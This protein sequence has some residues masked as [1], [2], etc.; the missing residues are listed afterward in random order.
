MG[1]W[2]L[3]NLR[4]WAVGDYNA[5]VD[6]K[7]RI[8]LRRNRSVFLPVKI[9]NYFQPILT[10]ENVN[11]FILDKAI[12]KHHRE[13]KWKSLN[14]IP[15]LITKAVGEERIEFLRD[16]QEKLLNE[17]NKC[18]EEHYVRKGRNFK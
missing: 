9:Q 6:S 15:N 18:T 11:K 2:D 12:K 5:K 7:E 8:S 13:W 16:H 1:I 3:S 4:R 14:P 10:K 17:I